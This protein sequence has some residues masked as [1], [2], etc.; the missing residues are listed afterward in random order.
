MIDS[1]STSHEL[2]GSTP[3]LSA[4]PIRLLLPIALFGTY[5][6]ALVFGVGTPWTPGRVFHIALPSFGLL[7]LASLPYLLA[8]GYR[9]TGA[10][11]RQLARWV[12]FGLLGFLVAFGLSAV[13]GRS[14]RADEVTVALGLV[15]LPV[16]FAV[17]PREFLPRRL[18][19]MLALLWGVNVLHA[20]LQIWVGG[21][22]VALA[23]NRN[24]AASLLACLL[25]W[26]WIEASRLR[27]ILF[28]TVAVASSLLTGYLVWLCHCRATWLALAA[29]AVLHVLVVRLRGHC[30]LFGFL[31]LALLLGIGTMAGYERIGRAM[32]DDIRLPL[33][34][35][36]LM[37]AAEFPVLGSGPGNFR[38]EYASRR[39]TEHQARRVTASVTEHP[40][41][42]LL[43]LAAE[44]GFPIAL[45]WAVLLAIALLGLRRGSGPVRQACHFSAFL[46]LLHGMLDKV[47]SAPPTSVLAVLFVGLLLRWRLPV[48]L[49]APDPRHRLLLR[50]LAG[51]AVAAG[52][53]LTVAMVWHGAHYRRAALAEDVGGD[54]LRYA[55]ALRR[56]VAEAGAAGQ[57]PDGAKALAHA[58]TV[59]A[60]GRREYERAYQE[61]VAA[62]RAA[63]WEARTHTLAGFCASR[64]LGDHARALDHYQR[65]RRL[66]PDFSHLNA[67]T[68]KALVAL[69]RGEEAIP[70]FVREAERFQ[71]DAGAW[72]QLFACALSARP[73]AVDL[74]LVQ[75]RI[76]ELRLRDA[77]HRL[78]G[79][80]DAL[81]SLAAAFALAAEGG[82]PG[83]TMEALALAREMTA[84]LPLRGVEATPVAT[85]DPGVFTEDDVRFWHLR[86]KWRNAWVDCSRED[87]RAL[88]A[89][90]QGLPDELR[91]SG[92]AEF[93]ESAGWRAVVVATVPETVELQRQITT[94]LVAPAT[95]RM[96]AGA[97][98]S[99][100][101]KDEGI[102]QRLGVRPAPGKARI[103]VR[104]GRQRLFERTQCLGF[105]LHRLLPDTTPDL[106]RSPLALLH[107][108]HQRLQRES[109]PAEVRM[110]VVEE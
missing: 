23:G 34:E 90:W 40:H 12:P 92:F 86:M 80:E 73:D 71:F 60:E 48:R 66:E 43:R 54:A 18:S 100:L 74:L 78:A 45:G 96:V 19:R 67:Y 98:I 88:L 72:M 30:R 69:G 94:A 20:I 61:L 89:A 16:F 2:P 85:G 52:A 84:D 47:L 4:L 105:F 68:G 14:V 56:S 7:A 17:V 6:L 21:E 50:G 107:T 25:P 58:E 26:V 63:P 87:I 44:I 97:G 37:L 99:Q 29:Y 57:S 65:A 10:W 33:Y 22:V 11:G 103:L 83:Q 77:A 15:C 38:R 64:H 91:Q 51:A 36:T 8:C 46:L 27:R 104:V 55:A 95:G 1:P 41:N 75:R 59:V 5:P 3:P 110:D 31:G 32:A 109:V 39:S 101:L 62:T 76:C 35:G 42:E 81:R 79:G 49:A 102:R 24:W 82:E 28:W 93:A 106:Y 70:F 53:Y 9:G 108:T 13:I